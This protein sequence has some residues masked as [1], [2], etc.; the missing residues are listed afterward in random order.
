[1]IYLGWH[2]MR[3]TWYRIYKGYDIE[4]WDGI[5]LDVNGECYV[6]GMTRTW[7]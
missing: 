6:S 3:L 7:N 5:W 2:T 4:F 1:M